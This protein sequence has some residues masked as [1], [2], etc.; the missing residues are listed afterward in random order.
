MRHLSINFLQRV[1]PSDFIL[2]FGSGNLD[3]ID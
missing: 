1:C 2:K 3:G